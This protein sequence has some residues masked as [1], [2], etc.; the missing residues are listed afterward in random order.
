MNKFRNIVMIFALILAVSLTSCDDNLVMQPT[1][2]TI[3]PKGTKV[4]ALN[5][6]P[7]QL[8]LIDEGIQRSIDNARLSGYNNDRVLNHSF[9]TVRGTDEP[10]VLYSG[11]YVMVVRSD[12]YDGSVY[13]KYNPLGELPLEQQTD[14][15][16][17]VKDGVGKVYSPE[18]ASESSEGIF[19][20]CMN[21]QGLATSAQY[22][23]EHIIIGNLDKNY[24]EVT[25]VHNVYA[26]PLLPKH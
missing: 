2:T 5:P 11:V 23:S 15:N 12:S 9:F 21:E 7:T 20:S 26:H 18:V 19:T 24:H 13:D 10:C 16:K 25:K 6:S 4:L 22:A 17:Y 1:T 14:F 3:T 8:N